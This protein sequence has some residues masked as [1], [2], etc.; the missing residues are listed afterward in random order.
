MV[1][2]PVSWLALLY[3]LYILWA[4]PTGVLWNDTYRYLSDILHCLSAEASGV[5]HLHS[6][7]GLGES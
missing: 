1:S 3:V 4:L 7:I 5:T 6:I 2:A